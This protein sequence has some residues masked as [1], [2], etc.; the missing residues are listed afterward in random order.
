MC[1]DSDLPSKL[2]Q[3]QTTDKL[4]DRDNDTCVQPFAKLTTTYLM[5]VYISEPWLTKAV[6]AI[7][8]KNLACN[9]P[10]APLVYL[11]GPLV[12]Q[13]ENCGDCQQEQMCYPYIYEPVQPYLQGSC[14]YYC[15]HMPTELRHIII[16]F[17]VERKNLTI[18][19]VYLL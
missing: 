11:D 4:W 13:D 8:G 14:L 17:V 6:I 12:V 7:Q 16:N 1:D 5:A 9:S 3:S 2:K 18:C 10:D 15:Y 19:E